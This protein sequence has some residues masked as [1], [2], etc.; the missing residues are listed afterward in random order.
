MIYN[1]SDVDIVEKELLNLLCDIVM[2]YIH[3][4]DTCHLCRIIF[5]NHAKTLFE[6]YARI[7]QMRKWKRKKKHF[8]Y[9][10]KT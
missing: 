1:F 10:F 2:Q 8:R 5:L 3:D 4:K 6:L 9:T 7:T